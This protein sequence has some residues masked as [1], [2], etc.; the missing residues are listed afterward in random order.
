MC[1][2]SRTDIVLAALPR[3]TK[4]KKEKEGGCR[5]V[6][7]FATTPSA[8]NALPRRFEARK[9]NVHPFRGAP[10]RGCGGKVASAVP[11]STCSC[12]AGTSA[13]A[14]SHW[15]CQ[16]RTYP[17]VAREVAS[18]DGRLDSGDSG[19]PGPSGVYAYGGG[20]SSIGRTLRRPRLK[21]GLRPKPSFSFAAGSC[22]Q[23]V[24]RRD[25]TVNSCP[26]DREKA[27][28]GWRALGQPS[29]RL[30]GRTSWLLN[31][32]RRRCKCSVAL[33][34]L[35]TF[36]LDGAVSEPERNLSSDGFDSGT[37]VTWHLRE[38]F[39]FPATTGCLNGRCTTFGSGLLYYFPHGG[40][41]ARKGGS[42][43]GTGSAA[44]S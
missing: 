39:F 6:S 25:L 8:T 11:T 42:L 24:P 17:R 4:R 7:K 38:Q 27:C 22:Y 19:Q 13:G 37:C 10:R 43:G 5:S 44:K 21:A 32:G 40:V 33:T 16:Q 26:K 2:T 12:V 29:G 1:S 23:L 14:R 15:A 36:V 30:S 34:S 20:H 31:G 35:P 28:G 18:A 41:R 9:K 3:E